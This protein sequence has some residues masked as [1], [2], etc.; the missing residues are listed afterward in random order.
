MACLFH[1]WNGCKCEK[2]DKVR[3][4]EHAWNG[5]CKCEKCGKT[6]DVGHTWNGCKCEKC[7]IINDELHTWEDNGK[8]TLICHNCEKKRIMVDYFNLD[9]NNMMLGMLM[10]SALFSIGVSNIKVL[11]EV[12]KVVEMGHIYADDTFATFLTVIKVL[13]NENKISESHYEQVLIKA[14]E[15]NQHL[16]LGMNIN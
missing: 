15:I 10:K 3:D 13:K 9:I 14:Q 7:G 12:E 8:G 5:G 16:S 1:K 2:C 4:S 11:D 6:R